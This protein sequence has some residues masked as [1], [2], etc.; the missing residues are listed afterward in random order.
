MRKNTGLMVLACVA[1]LA[2]C[3]DADGMYDDSDNYGVSPE[4]SV[5]RSAL[6]GYC[7]INVK[8]ESTGAVKTVDMETD[9]IPNVTHCENGGAPYETLRAQAVAPR[10]FAY[11]K[12]NSGVTAIRDSTNDQ[13]YSC[14]SRA[15]SEERL[16]S[17]KSA[18][19]DTNGIVLR[20]G[21]TTI[22]AFYRAGVKEKYL[23]ENCMF[24]GDSTSEGYVKNQ[25]AVTYNWGKSGSDLIKSSSG[26]SKSSANSGCYSQN[27]GMCLA[28][29]G[30]TW[31]NIVR[32][33]YGM[34]IGIER[35]D[36]ECVTH[37]KCTAYLDGSSTIIDD[38]DECF[39]RNTS[40]NYFTLGSPLSVG[41]D[42][43]GYNDSL[44]FAYTWDGD[45]TAVGTWKVSVKKAGP[46]MV[47]AYIDSKAGS[48]S[49]KAPYTIRANNTEKAVIVD[50]TKSSGWV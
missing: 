45:A 31:E 38:R 24:T 30:W 4:Y 36:A 7:S 26:S 16:N 40:D 42:K 12:L 8:N 46:Y 10:S 17:M 3:S 47:S 5:T 48:L 14:P 1:F 50:L 49:Q 43:V 35:V 18:A 6:S 13:V 39:V 33:F 19:N 32:F 9:Y 29:K 11:Y 2:G 27:G 37:P 34:D 23:D 28:R 44:Q 41:S 25:N 15:P 20:R 21:T 22:C